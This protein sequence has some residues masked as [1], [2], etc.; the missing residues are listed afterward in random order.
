MKKGLIVCVL[1]LLL[2][3]AAGTGVRVVYAQDEDTAFSLDTENFDYQ[4]TPVNKLGRGI[5]N[6]A[7]CWAEIPGEIARVSK[8][9]DPVIGFT[10]GLA[11]GT[12]NTIIRGAV[13]IFDMLTFLVPP[14]NKPEMKPE[15]ALQSADKNIS[16]Y[17]W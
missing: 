2:L 6:T 9:S 12:I 5:V 16:D 8:Q 7:S 13:G 14:Y 10:L 4:N 3:M 15:Y 17:L 1:V 11:Q